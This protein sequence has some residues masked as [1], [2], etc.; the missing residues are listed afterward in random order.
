M[1][2][3]VLTAA[4]LIF[5]LFAI[6]APA[7][8]PI[9]PGGSSIGGNLQPGDTEPIPEGNYRGGTDYYR[10]GYSFSGDAGERF[11][12]DLTA[13][14][15]CYLILYGP[16]GMEIASNDDFGTTTRS[17]I[18]VTLPS[19]GTH[20]AIVTSFG[21]MATGTYQLTVGEPSQPAASTSDSRISM[22]QTIEGEITPQDN[23]L[24]IGERG[25]SEYHRDGYRFRAREGQAVVIEMV[26]S[27]D[28]YL[29]LFNPDGQLITSNDDYGT[30]QASRIATTLGAAG[31]HR[32]VVTTYSPGQTGPYTLTVREGEA[33]DLNQQGPG[34]EFYNQMY[35]GMQM[36]GPNQLPTQLYAQLGFQAPGEH[37]GAT[38]TSTPGEGRMQLMSDPLNVTCRVGDRFLTSAHVLNTST[39]GFDEVVIAVDYDP[40][41]LRPLRV[42]DHKIRP[43]LVESPTLTSD[44]REGWIRYEARLAAPEKAMNRE[45]ITVEWETLAM[46]DRTRVAF[47]N[48]P[49]I[50][51][52]LRVQGVDLLGNLGQP[53]DGT[54]ATDVAI[55]WRGSDHMLSSPHS[56]SAERLR[57]LYGLE[58][59]GDMTLRLEGPGRAIT[60]GDTFSVDIVLDNPKRS[61]F[62]ELRLLLSYDPEVLEVLDSAP[63]GYPPQCDNWIVR[64]INLLD[65]PFHAAFPFD[66]HLRNEADSRFGTVNYH[67]GLNRPLPLEGGT[68]ARMELR[69]LAPAA[70]TS[71]R[72]IQTEVPGVSTTAVRCLGVDMLG[73][74]DVPTDGT[75]GLRLRIE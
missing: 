52:A 40:S 3:P 16:E 73:D 37:R 13:D 10:D 71:L 43:L 64:G 49:E 19:S 5:L 62:D 56:N 44:L 14:F 17:H 20:Y 38:P 45:I 47:I 22:G 68:V 61:A 70:E 55:H 41:V 7:M 60:V 24:L 27:F 35:S 34:P 74:L 57:E 33:E 31:Q 8:Q 54:L 69:V 12:I 23:A 42:S 51:C 75:R 53:G 25:G 66:F 2:H 26:C 4:A 28:G 21:A 18:D 29:Y 11:V 9:Q 46:V 15:D 32:V 50:G 65:E 58:T 67:M 72:F 59:V 39:C 6:G 48:D 1:R 63:M 36:T 30:V